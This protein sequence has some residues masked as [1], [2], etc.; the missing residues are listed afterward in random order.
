MDIKMKKLR[1]FCL[2]Q[3]KKSQQQK[4]TEA[5]KAGVN[6]QPGANTNLYSH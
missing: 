4:K 1:S 5:L 3:L 6:Q 2:A